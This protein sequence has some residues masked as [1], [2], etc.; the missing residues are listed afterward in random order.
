VTPVYL[1]AESDRERQKRFKH[2]GCLDHAIEAISFNMREKILEAEHTFQ[3]ASAG[4][5]FCRHEPAE[6][7][8]DGAAQNSG[9]NERQA[10]HAERPADGGASPNRKKTNYEPST[11][12][13]RAHA[14]RAAAIVAS[15]NQ[16]RENV[17]L[18]DG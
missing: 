7:A 10:S 3:G 6:T 15:G 12:I 9:N 13:G 8:D 16:G 5:C 17:V 1:H 11:E 14:V 2:F 4:Y 18:D